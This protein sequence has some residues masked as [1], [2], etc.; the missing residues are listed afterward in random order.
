VLHSL[1]TIKPTTIEQFG[2][3]SGIGEHKKQKYGT[4]FL[5]LIQ[6]YV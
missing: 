2:A 1:A 3:I 5:A 4:R 6:K